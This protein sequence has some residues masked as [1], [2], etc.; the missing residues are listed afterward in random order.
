MLQNVANKI[1]LSIPSFEQFN[2]FSLSIS[3]NLKYL[4]YLL[5]SS[6]LNIFIFIF[7]KFFNVMLSFVINSIIGNLLLE[8]I[9]F[10][11]SFKI[12]K[13]VLVVDF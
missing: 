11:N 9:L 13:N 6:I 5:L 1:Y 2:I 3:V 7:I 4:Q 10:D 8:F 12:L